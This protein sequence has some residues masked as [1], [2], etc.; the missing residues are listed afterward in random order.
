M[1]DAVRRDSIICRT[2]VRTLGQGYARGEAK[3]IVDLSLKARVVTDAQ[4]EALEKLKSAVDLFEANEYREAGLLFED[5]LRKRVLF[6]DDFAAYWF[7]ES[8][9]HQGRYAEAVRQLRIVVR[10]YPTSKWRDFALA[11]LGDALLASGAWHEAHEIYVRH[12]QKYPDYPH[13]GALTLGLAKTK[14]K[15]EQ[16]RAAA[17]ISR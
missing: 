11:R 17:R 5:I 6:V 16:H 1:H 7:A 13:P 3:A 9:F 14:M 15:M 10:D 4:T 12:Q 2:P 8:L